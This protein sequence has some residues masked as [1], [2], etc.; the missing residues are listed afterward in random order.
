MFSPDDFTSITRHIPHNIRFASL[1]SEDPLDIVKFSSI[2][3]E[4]T[5]VLIGERMSESISLESV[6]ELM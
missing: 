4:D 3:L 5:V 2:S 6:F 1:F